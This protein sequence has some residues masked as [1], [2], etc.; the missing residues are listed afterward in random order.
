[1][2]TLIR[3]FIFG[4]FTNTV[5]LYV[6]TLVVT[7]FVFQGDLIALAITGA[8]LTVINLLVK[9]ILRLLFGPLILLTLGLFSIVINALTLIIL[10]FFSTPLTIQGYAP[11]LYGTLIIAAVNL[12]LSFLGHRGNTKEQ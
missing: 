11:L 5:A 7:G 12:L 6:A 3:N 4:T 10:D 2:G 9:P 8:I 1:M